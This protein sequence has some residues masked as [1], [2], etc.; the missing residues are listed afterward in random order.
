MKHKGIEK[1]LAMLQTAGR[2]GVAVAKF[3]LY[4]G[5]GVV[6]D[7]VKMAATGLPYKPSTVG[8]I[9]DAVGITTMRDA[10]DGVETTVGFDGYFDT[11]FP[12]PYFVREVEAG[13]SVI[14]KR[15]FIKKA[16]TAC[17]AQAMAA[18]DRA[19]T[20]KLEEITSKISGG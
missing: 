13:T 6:A 17:T 9:A 4:E 11:G 15:P 18:M 3:A 2:A 7:R 5:A 20:A 12:I 16:V 14:P 19:G 10:H 1:E 8:Q